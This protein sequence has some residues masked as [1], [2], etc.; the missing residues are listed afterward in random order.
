MNV[1]CQGRCQDLVGGGGASTNRK[2]IRAPLMILYGPG[3]V[4]GAPPPRPLAMP[5]VNAAVAFHR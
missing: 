4:W 2:L 1:I 3:Q 5:L